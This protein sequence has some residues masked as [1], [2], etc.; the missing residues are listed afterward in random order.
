MMLDHILPSMQ[1]Q[2]F[3]EWAHTSFEQS[4]AELFAIPHEE[5]IQ[6]A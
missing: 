2:S 1:P 4:P 5:H 3:L 6:V